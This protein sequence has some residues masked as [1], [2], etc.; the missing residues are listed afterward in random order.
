MNGSPERWKGMI[1]MLAILVGMT[2][3]LRVQIPGPV[4]PGVLSV[5]VLLGA[6]TWILTQAKRKGRR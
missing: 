5:A 2:L 4:L 3:S 6:G 1:G